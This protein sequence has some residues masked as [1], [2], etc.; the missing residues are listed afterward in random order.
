MTL[1]LTETLMDALIWFIES[2]GPGGVVLIT[3]IENI[4]LPL[5][6]EVVL[7]FAGYV[8]W[9]NGSWIYVVEA[10]L[11]AS[12]GSI[13]GA[14]LLYYIGSAF[15]RPFIEKYGRYMMIKP[16]DVEA[17]ERWFIRY[18]QLSV[19]FGRMVPA[20]RTLISLPAGIFEMRLPRFLILTFLGTLPWNLSL[21]SHGYLL[22]PNWEIIREYSSVIDL[23]GVAIIVGLALYLVLKVLGRRAS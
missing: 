11:A 20:I 21:T 19:F 23:A 6:S 2:F 15:G 22:G 4:V 5:P 12:L 18:G 8:A 1:G 14:V 10:S 17:A 3:F 9:R 13:L 7:A 16:K